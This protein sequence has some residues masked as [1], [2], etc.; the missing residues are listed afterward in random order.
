MSPSPLQSSHQPARDLR[1][2]LPSPAGRRRL[3][4]PRRDQQHGIVRLGM[5]LPVVVCQSNQRRFIHSS[6][7]HAPNNGEA[8]CANT[9]L[10]RPVA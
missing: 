8:R 7:H 9:C 1:E 2:G 10:K 4:V 5:K 3:Q 6:A